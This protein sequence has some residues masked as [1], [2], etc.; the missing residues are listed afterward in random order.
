MNECEKKL[1]SN[2]TTKKNILNIIMKQ[3]NFITTYIIRFVTNEESRMLAL[4]RKNAT[5]EEA[6][7]LHIDLSWTTCYN[8]LC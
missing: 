4:R 8:D 5:I 2:V 7:N 6:Y 1:E 3:L